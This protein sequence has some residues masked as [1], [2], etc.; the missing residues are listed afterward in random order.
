MKA[1]KFYYFKSLFGDYDTDAG[2]LSEEILRFFFYVDQFLK[3]LLNLLQLRLFFLMLWLTDHKA[4]GILASQPG[5]E[6][7]HP[8]LEGEIL[9]T[10]PPG[11]SLRENFYSALGSLGRLNC[12]CKGKGELAVL[13]TRHQKCK[14]EHSNLLIVQM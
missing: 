5:I 11:K 4:C 6:P 14:L 2:G 3:S 10:G 7:T 12:F 8:A 1:K 9:T 13:T